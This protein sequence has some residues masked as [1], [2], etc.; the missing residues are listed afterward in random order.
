M[1]RNANRL[2]ISENELLEYIQSHAR[3]LRPEGFGI[4]AQE[5]MEKSHV[6]YDAAKRLLNGLVKIG[7]LKKQV[8]IQNCR[9]Y[10]VFYK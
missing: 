4:T 8:M 7:K 2:N 3:P 5:Y 6:G 1:K 10:N 9:P